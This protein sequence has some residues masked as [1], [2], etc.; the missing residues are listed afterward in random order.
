MVVRLLAYSSTWKRR[1]TPLTMTYFYRNL[2]FMEFEVTH[3]TGFVVTL[4]IENILL[5]L[6]EKTSTPRQIKCG[7]PQGSILGPTL[8]LIYINDINNSTNYFN[9]RLFADDTNVFKSLDS[10]NI[11]LNHV[12]T[13]L[14]KINNWCIAN[15]LTI[16]SIG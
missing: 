10:H 14:R 1:S 2:N 5:S 16:K 8:F 4:K 7:V 6:M 15:K 12:N 13:E 11:N 3:Y 9:F